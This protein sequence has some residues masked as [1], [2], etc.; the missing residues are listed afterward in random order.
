M[1][2]DDGVERV[3]SVA[4]R[5][6]P[7]HR[8]LVHTRADLRSSDARRALQ[9]VDVLF[10]LGFQ[11]WRDR[12]DPT[13]ARANL[14]GTANVLAAGPARVVFASSA[15]VYGAWPD[16]PL[17]IDEGH[18]PRPN[19]ECPYAEQKLVA[20]RM[21]A[22][23]AATVVLRIGAVLGPHADPRVKRAATAYRR[24]VP[25]A[26]GV[27]TALQFVHEDDVAAALLAAGSSDA[28]G[29]FNVA[30]DDW[31]SPQD[32]ARLSGGRV[33]TLPLRWLVR[34]SEV[35]YRLRVLPFGADRAV[36]LNGPLALDPSRAAEAFGWR[37]TRSSE[38]TLA[39]FLGRGAVQSGR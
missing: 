4:R 36:L 8:K 29:T 19:R 10:H 16:N 33:V 32:I 22:D 15:A 6:L 39:E 2:A 13:A 38:H 18:P 5:P 31:L 17:P 34:G 24:A 30:T 20:E 1:L 27:T 35:A 12:R 28:T 37:T 23:A 26:R 9:G 7:S 21:C 25:V 11:L 3:R 14:H